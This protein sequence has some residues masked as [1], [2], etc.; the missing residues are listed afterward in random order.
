MESL[1]RRVFGWVMSGTSVIALLPAEGPP[2]FYRQTLVGGRGTGFP[3]GGRVKIERWTPC[4]AAIASR[5]YVGLPRSRGD[6][7]HGSEP[8]AKPSDPT[9][10]VEA[11]SRGWG[12]PIQ[13]ATQARVEHEDSKFN[14]IVFCVMIPLHSHRIE[15]V[16]F[17]SDGRGDN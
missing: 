12:R 11:A 4:P 8:S 1:S 17:A 2:V 16:A 14:A 15:F 13:P 6:A 7:E 3:P 10:P 5:R 9:S